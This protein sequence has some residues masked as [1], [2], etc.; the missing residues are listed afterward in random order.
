[1]TEDNKLLLCAAV[2]AVGALSSGYHLYM[3][4]KRAEKRSKMGVGEWLE[5][6][7]I[8]VSMFVAAAGAA[9]FY[10]INHFLQE[11]TPEAAQ[12]E[13]TEPEYETIIINGKKYELIPVE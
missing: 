13:T 8:L 3:F 9:P 7:V 6:A 11:Q 4:D 2:V 5:L 1:M 12:Q 10:S